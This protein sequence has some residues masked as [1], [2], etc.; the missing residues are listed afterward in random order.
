MDEAGERLLGVSMDGIW[1]SLL[2]GYWLNN[3]CF[4]IFAPDHGVF[5]T[6]VVRDVMVGRLR[7]L[8]ASRTNRFRK[9]L[10]EHGMG[11]AD[12]RAPCAFGWRAAHTCLLALGRQMTL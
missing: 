11:I 1:C 9:S 12:R 4:H 7:G 6:F 2:Q 10:L 5:H 3:S 8:W